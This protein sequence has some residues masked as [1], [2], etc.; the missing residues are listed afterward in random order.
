METLRAWILTDGKAGDEN[1]CIAV[2][3]ALGLAYA[4]RRVAPRLPWSLAMPRGPVDPREAPDRPG[5]PIAPPFP[6]IAIASGRRAV[7]YLRRVKR[8]S[9]GR[10][11][12]VFLKDPRTGSGA[13]DLVWVPEHDR[14]RGDNVIVTPA[15][16]HRHSAAKLAEARKDPWPE[17]AALAHP[18]V[19]VLA[20][21][22]SRSHRYAEDDI[23]R[24]A[25]GLRAFAAQGARLMIT[26]SRRTPAGL[27]QALRAIAAEGRHLLWEGEG[28]NPLLQYLA[29]ADAVVATADSANMVGEALATGR[30]VHV[31]HPSGGH[32]KF[33]AFL[34]AL[35]GTNA[36]H[37]FP[38]PLKVTTYEPI[39]STPEIADA[40]RQRLAAHR[41]GLARAAGGGSTQGKT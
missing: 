29:N 27:A 20:G 17:I 35:S 38:G 19:A 39:D 32:R 24:F 15:G 33:D 8:E 9:G 36:V 7:A 25:E 12:T 13:A 5:S 10:T 3:E 41:A 18:R 26:T 34:G 28:A 1:Q 30:A 4:L 2:A 6:D 31:F 40:I 22:D 21:G 37:P 23:A 11:F 16:P 14:L